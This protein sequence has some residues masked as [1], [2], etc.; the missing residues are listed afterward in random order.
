MNSGIIINNNTPTKINNDIINF[1]LNKNIITFEKKK[2]I[3]SP[4]IWFGYHFKPKKSN[5]F[6]SFEIKFYDVIPKVNSGFYFK[7]HCPHIYYDTWLESCSLNKFTK[8][9]FEVSAYKIKNRFVIKPYIFILDDY[10]NKCK[11]EIKNFK[12]HYDEP[13]NLIIQKNYQLKSLDI[14]VKGYIY[15]KSWTPTSTAKRQHRRYQIDFFKLIDGYEK[16]FNILKNKYDV[17]ITFITYDTISDETKSIFK[18]KDWNI[19]FVNEKGSR[20]FTGLKNNIRKFNTNLLVIRTDLILKEE[21]NTFLSKYKFP[22]NITC[23]T[24]EKGGRCNDTVFFIPKKYIG[25]MKNILELK[26]NRGGKWCHIFPRKSIPINIIDNTFKGGTRN[27]KKYF[28]I[29]RG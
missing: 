22:D 13:D 4:Y 7:S 15:K 23:L 16:L 18:K 20:Q 26:K 1:T 2:P 3:Y 25:D 17:K 28:T 5:F 12:I 29:F 27:Y 14:I 9:N 11:F 21:F 19:I 8:I 6:V 24:R 10:K